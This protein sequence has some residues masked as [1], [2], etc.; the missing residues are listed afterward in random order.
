[1]LMGKGEGGKAGSEAGIVCETA[2]HHSTLLQYAL[3]SSFDVVRPL[4]LA[5]CIFGQGCTECRYST[6]GQYIAI[7][8]S[9]AITVVSSLSTEVQCVLRGHLEKVT[10]LQWSPDDRFL[11][12]CALD[13]RVFRCVA[14]RANVFLLHL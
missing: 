4:W 5:L 1:M 7:A 8:N 9:A 13:G 14:C 2:C 6:G 10:C 12:S 11:F 3:P